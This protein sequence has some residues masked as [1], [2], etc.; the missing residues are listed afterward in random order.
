MTFVKTATLSW[1]ANLQTGWRNYQWRRLNGLREAQRLEV[2][3]RGAPP[4]ER[5][6]SWDP[7]PW[8]HPWLTPDNLRAMRD[9]SETC[10]TRWQHEADTPHVG[11]SERYA[12]IGNLANNMYMRARPL[13]RLGLDIDVYLHPQDH[14]VMSQPGWEELHGLIESSETDMRRLREQGVTLPTVPGVYQS[15]ESAPISAQ[16][17]YLRYPHLSARDVLRWLP[18]LNGHDWLH[19]LAGYDAL[20]CAQSTFVGLLSGQPYV[21]AHVG[22][23][24]WY[25][26]S[27]GDLLGRLQLEAYRRAAVMLASNPW[28]FAHA[29]RYGL[30]NAIY[31]PL[32]LDEEFYAPGPSPF[33]QT[34]M[35]SSGG[36]FFVFSAV[37]QN[38][39]IKG[40]LTGLEGFARFA[41]NRPGARLVIVEW[42]Q[43]S[44]LNLERFAALG[45]SDKV[46]RVPI[47]G[48]RRVVDYLRSADCS[49]DQ[50]TLGY[51]GASALEAMG[52][53]LP[54]IMRIEHAQYAALCRA[55]AP[56]VVEAA[57]A[58]EV[59]SALERLRANVDLRRATASAQRDWFVAAHG[60]KAWYPALVAML[61]VTATGR[62]E[63]FAHSPLRMRLSTVERDYH[64]QGLAR[65]PKFPN[66]Q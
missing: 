8:R 66:Y 2:L 25:E 61:R 48:K 39:A 38:D 50:F 23:D 32:V 29:R 42:G 56:P 55:G 24:I 51:Y 53:G 54:V 60:A 37:R 22:G 26:C 41:A 7:A 27:R 21:A 14:Y 62:R 63:R 59:A 9:Y 4:V 57:T 3:W 19:E 13:R 40:T 6:D 1:S 28:S 20:L 45:I 44:D 5:F 15:P 58:G 46:I 34:W 33:R 65:A 52:C 43:Q 16:E 31:V 18:Y 10:L 11:Q 64:T 47:A 30:C 49:I 35:N 36:D 12:F 17:A